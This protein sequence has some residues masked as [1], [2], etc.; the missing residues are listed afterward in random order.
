MAHAPRLEASIEKTTGRPEP[1]FADTTYVPRPASAF[2]GGADVKTIVCEATMGGVGS[3]GCGSGAAGGAVGCVVGGCG[4][5]GAGGVGA[6]TGLDGDDSSGTRS[7]S[8]RGSGGA[9]AAS[10]GA[11]ARGSSCAISDT[12]PDAARTRRRSAASS[13]CVGVNPSARACA[14]R[15]AYDGRPDESSMPSNALWSEMET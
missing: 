5:A 10:T 2:A 15:D 3:G 11:S 8:D 1:A 4:D 12:L 7:G 13:C 14:F 6:G 9:A